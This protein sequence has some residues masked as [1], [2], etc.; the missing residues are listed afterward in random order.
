MESKNPSVRKNTFQFAAEELAAG[1]MT[2]SGAINKSGFLLMILV[3]TAALNW[4]LESPLLA[5]AGGLLG[6]ISVLVIVFNKRL[7]PY[8]AP[9]YAAF[10]G[11]TIGF[12]SVLAD[13]AYP[14]VAANAMTLTFATLGLMLFCYRMGILRATPMFKR[15]VVFATLAIA[16]TYLVNLVMG[17][18]GAR[19]AMIHEASPVGIAFSV[20]VTG[21]AALNLILDF[22]LFERNA[23][24][25]PKYMEWYCGFSLLITLV[26]LYLEMIRLLGKL[27]KK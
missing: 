16:L 13:R 7:S 3:A 22:D 25:S 8:L 10:E 23:E 11:L 21:V 1:T 6:L 19:I 24:R 9:A 15:V 5:L 26:W 20:I 12:I 4:S 17:F 14:G 18:W 27:N 2:M